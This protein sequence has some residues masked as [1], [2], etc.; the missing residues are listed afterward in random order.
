MYPGD[1]KCALTVP[2]AGLV[3]SLGV[4]KFVS[5]ALLTDRSISLHI[6][7]PYIIIFYFDKEAASAFLRNSQWLRH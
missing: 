3:V 6:S 1:G 5:P 4:N 7:L 2:Q